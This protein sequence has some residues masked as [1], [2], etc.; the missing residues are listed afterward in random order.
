MPQAEQLARKLQ[1]QIDISTN[2]AEM[3]DYTDRVFLEADNSY[4]A[5]NYSLELT[6]VDLE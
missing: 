3:L 2:L 5:K 6:Q 4:R 1:G